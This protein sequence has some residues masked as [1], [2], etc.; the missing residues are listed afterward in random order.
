MRRII[1]AGF[2][3]I[4]AIEASA[5]GFSPPTATAPV[6]VQSLPKASAIGNSDLLILTHQTST[7]PAL[8]QTQGMTIQ[9]LGQLMLGT[10]TAGQVGVYVNPGSV[11]SGQ[12]PFAAG[13]LVL[14]AGVLGL[15]SQGPFSADLPIFGNGA[16]GLKA[17]SKQGTT[18]SVA[19]T[20]GAFVSGNCRSTDANGNEVDAGSACVAGTLANVSGSALNTTANCVI[21]N[22]AITLAAARDFVNGQGISLEHCGT[23]FATAAPTSLAVASTGSFSQGPAG[24]TTYSYQIA[25]VDDAGGVGAAVAAV[26]ITN[27]AATLNAITRFPGTGNPG[28]LSFNAVSWMNSGNCPGVAV[29]RKVAAGPFHLI[30]IFQA[31]ADDGGTPPNI[32]W[33]TGW[34]PISIPFIPDTPTASALADRFV[35]T[36]SSGGGTTSLVLAAAPTTAVTGAYVRHDD[37]AAITTYLTGLA[38]GSRAT[39][40]AGTF[41]TESLTIPT[42]LGSWAGAG[43]AASQIVG[44]NAALP[45]VT[46][47][48]LANGFSISGMK[49][50][51]LSQTADGLDITT[52]QKAQV[53][54]MEL[55]GLVGL[56]LVGDS[57]YQVFG[58]TFDKVARS[59][60]LDNTGTSNVITNNIANPCLEPASCLIVFIEASNLDLVTSN[61]LYGPDIFGVEVFGGNFNNVNGNSVYNSN[62]ESYEIASSGT[63]NVING[64]WG[65]SGSVGIDYC[66]SIS[67]GGSTSVTLADNV[68]SNNYFANCGNAAIA[69]AELTPGTGVSIDRIVITNNTILSPNQNGLVAPFNSAIILNGSGVT[70]T[71]INGNT[72]LFATGTIAYNVAEVNTLGLGFPAATEVGTMFGNIGGMATTSLSGVG[73]AALTAVITSHSTGF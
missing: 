65:N 6:T 43:R 52:S 1:L 59:A 4:A 23:A 31:D 7:Q 69:V 66:F 2:L 34:A 61:F 55:G 19:V 54:A 16:S 73:S 35:T 5:Q 42:V 9:Q 39:L 44:W 3:A 24:S 32:V 47:T 60:I 27:G 70:S 62:H 21:S 15:T 29:W 8:Y 22:P 36:I 20:A 18:D 51:P 26:T 68:I 63:S 57:N 30:G 56:H 50:A 17:G 64:N 33:D 48:S 11:L 12:G 58:N 25:C 13:S 45:A 46:G 38:A 14:G 37:T 72:F 40:P 10:G 67:D 49:I 41:N 28:V 71:M 53:T